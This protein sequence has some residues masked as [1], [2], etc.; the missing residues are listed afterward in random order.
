MCILT[1]VKNKYCVGQTKSCVSSMS[2]AVSPL[3][4]F[5]LIFYEGPS[6]C[7]TRQE[8]LD[9]GILKESETKKAI[10][11]REPERQT[12]GLRVCTRGNN[13]SIQGLGPQNLVQYTLQI[14]ISRDP[15][16][17]ST[18]CYLSSSYCLFLWLPLLEARECDNGVLSQPDCPI[19]LVLFSLIVQSLSLM[20]PF[21]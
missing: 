12:S 1:K 11:W 9:G 6:G 10:K 4:S 13:L 3:R 18:F 17:L 19:K 15:P 21:F 2:P 14:H 16:F 8:I 20:V 5:N 7:F